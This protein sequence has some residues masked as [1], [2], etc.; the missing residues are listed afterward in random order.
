M[1]WT[2]ANKLAVG[3]AAVIAIIITLAV[4]ESYESRKIAVETEHLYQRGVRG[5]A[6][7]GQAAALLQRV[8]GNTFHHVAATSPDE[9]SRIEEQ[10][11]AYEQELLAALDAYAALAQASGRR[12]S[13]LSE[14]RRKYDVFAAVRTE[15]VYPASR[16]DNT[17]TALEVMSQVSGPRFTAAVTTL[18]ELIDAH[19]DLGER[20]HED[21]TR[22][23]ERANL[24]SLVGSV[25]AVFLA[26]LI[27]ALVSRNI[28]TRLRTVAVAARRVTTGKLDTRAEVGGSDEIT[29]VA[30]ALN[31]MTEA[32][33]DKIAAE[34][35][36]AD[37]EAEERRRL[38]ET[39]RRYGDF[40][41]R[42]ARGELTAQLPDGGIDELGRLGTNLNAMGKALR[43]MTLRIH[44]AVGALSS[45]TAEILA[46]V[47]EHSSSATESA[48]AVAETAATVDEVQQSAQRAA[49]QAQHVA[50]VSRQSVQVSAAGRQAVEHTVTTMS[51]VRSQ[52]DGIAERIL[53]LSEQTQAVGHIISTVNELSEQSNLLA[54]N[55]SIE[56]ARA[57][58]EGRGFAVVAQEIRGLADQSREA[59]GQVRAILGD[60]Q[61]STTDAVLATEEGSK[62]VVRAVD[63]VRA[64]GE[65]IEQLAG[66]ISEVARAAESILTAA[67]QQAQGV[68]QISQAMHAIDEASRQTVEGT[69]NVEGAARGLNELAADLRDAVT[70][71]RT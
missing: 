49:E 39:V 26:I 67:Q 44:E 2:V 64:A 12:Q 11:A 47:Q 15:Q 34:Q 23:L 5:T 33:A 46:T 65:R 50:D 7:L 24:L 60:I 61:K 48:S 42:V 32:L 21:A 10:I 28:V 16:A 54:L 35:Q 43:T 66:T 71:Y 6:A 58:E 55:A 45:A 69:R 8:R 30:A 36:A 68:G 29:E 62:A 3:F 41:D 63:A 51:D 1:K 52:V 14:L 19:V 4:V 20:T 9:R 38:A 17:A 57:G 25:L 31:G 70:Q 18:N 37:T 40:V 13:L 53:S 27:A 59:T 22:A 56:A